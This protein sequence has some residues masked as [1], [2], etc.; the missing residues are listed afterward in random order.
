MRA[1][2]RASYALWPRHSPCTGARLTADEVSRV[3]IRPIRARSASRPPCRDHGQAGEP[4]RQVGVALSSQAPAL[5]VVDGAHRLFGLVDRVE[6]RVDTDGVTRPDQAL[7]FLQ[8]FGHEAP[9]PGLLREAG[10]V[11]GYPR[12]RL[13]RRPGGLEEGAL[14]VRRLA[15][16]HGE[17]GQYRG[18][19]LQEITV[20]IADQSVAPPAWPDLR[21]CARGEYADAQVRPVGVVEDQPRRRH[22]H[23][24]AG[25]R[26][27][28]VNRVARRPAPLGTI[29]PAVVFSLRV[30][31]REFR[32]E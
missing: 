6:R 16:H 32:R 4:A 25:R 10:Q 8:P 1:A 18:A 19:R 26:A 27:L 28:Q 31:R 21:I 15:H 7:A 23:R 22:A 20:E 14:P 2:R 5:A 3:F 24:T 11:A 9:V 17:R 29:K 12:A 13:L 30:G